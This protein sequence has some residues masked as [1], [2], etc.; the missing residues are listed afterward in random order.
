MSLHALLFLLNFNEYNTF[1]IPF[2]IVACFHITWFVWNEGWKNEFHWQKCINLLPSIYIHRSKW[3]HFNLTDLNVWIL[4][5]KK[6]LQL[7][8]GSPW[9]NYSQVSPPPPSPLSQDTHVHL[10][11]QSLSDTWDSLIPIKLQELERHTVHPL[12]IAFDN[13]CDTETTSC[14]AKVGNVPSTVQTTLP[15]RCVM[16]VRLNKLH[17][18][19]M[20]PRRGLVFFFEISR[21]V[22]DCYFVH[23]SCSSH[24]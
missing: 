21:K 17:K 2:F 24:V 10:L 14:I 6:H 20:T 11:S 18:R 9:V 15:V 5:M 3:A 23:L 1:F 19:A 22:M 8:Q 12:L 7:K 16:V 13:R 4:K